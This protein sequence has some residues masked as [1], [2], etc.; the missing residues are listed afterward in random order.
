MD[1]NSDIKINFALNP[2]EPL[3][4]TLIKY[5]NFCCHKYNK[6]KKAQWLKKN[7]KVE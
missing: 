6:Q 7:K 3:N 4:R 2:N 5:S 1:G